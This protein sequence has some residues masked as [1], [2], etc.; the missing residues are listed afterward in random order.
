MRI[1][2]EELTDE[3]V[4][5]RIR[6]GESFLFEIIMRR[7]NQRLFRVA[8]SILKNE[9]E[10]EDVIQDAYVRAYENLH[11]F[12]GEAKFSTW[13][14]KI[15]IYESL[16]RMRRSKRFTSMEDF[17][18]GKEIMSILKDENGN[19]EKDFFRRRVIELLENAI[20]N[21]STK[22]SLVIMLRDV[23]GL[24]TEETARCLGISEEAVKTRLH[25][26]RSVLRKELS[27]GAGV[28]VKDLYPFAGERCDRIVAAV[29]DRIRLLPS[30]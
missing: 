29:M 13:L 24:S 3:E 9:G 16:R 17:T 19:P 2:Q 1:V 11:Q 6:S 8:K 21:L 10:A 22:Y 26:A 18:K 14:T 30:F 27:S 5:R 15:A 23:E 28:T 20:G 7:Y 25:R 12:A 4:V